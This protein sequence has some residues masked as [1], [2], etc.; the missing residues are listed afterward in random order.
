MS[1]TGGS[2]KQTVLYAFAAERNGNIPV[3]GVILYK[4]NLYGTTYQGGSSGCYKGQGCG[5]V[6]ELRHTKA[7]WAEKVLHRFTAG[8][9]GEYP[10]WGSLMVDQI[11]NLYG[12]TTN[13]GA[14][15]YGDVFEITGDG[16]RS[17]ARFESPY[18]DGDSPPRIEPSAENGAGLGKSTLVNSS[19]VLL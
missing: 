2:W 3:D 11:G 10:K 4:G 17:P 18:N 16:D 13:G 12:T 9:D 5:A 6:F 1:H 19:R 7:G 15:G 14:Y 8:N